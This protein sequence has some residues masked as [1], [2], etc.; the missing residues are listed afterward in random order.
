M[1]TIEISIP[2]TPPYVPLAVQSVA[3]ANPLAISAATYKDWKCAA[4]SG[5]TTVNLTGATDGDGGII[6]LIISGAGGYTITMGVM[7]TKNSG[8]AIDATTAVDNIIVWFKSGTDIIYNIN[9]IL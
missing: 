9:Q 8:G 6:E 5:N 4:V 3:F 7:F 1:E 2:G